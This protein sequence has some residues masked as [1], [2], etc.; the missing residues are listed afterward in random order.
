MSDYPHNATTIINNNMQNSLE[1]YLSHQLRGY[2]NQTDQ[3]PPSEYLISI[4]HC[5]SSAV[6]SESFKTR[7][8]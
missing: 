4:Y 1:E 8:L 7:F 2:H 5:C 3:V 6:G